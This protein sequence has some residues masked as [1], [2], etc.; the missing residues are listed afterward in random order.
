MQT[1]LYTYVQMN[2]LKRL[3]ER[4]AFPAAILAVVFKGIAM[5]VL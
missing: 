5:Y 2:K 3:I 4:G 1:D